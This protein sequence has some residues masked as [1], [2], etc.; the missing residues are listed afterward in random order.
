[1]NDY[2]IRTRIA[3]EGKPPL[4]PL[5]HV[6]E[7]R[8]GGVVM[9]DENVKVTCA[10]VDHP[11]VVPAFACR[12]DSADRSIVISGDTQRS[13]ALIRLAKDADVLVHEV[14]YIPA[15]DRLAARV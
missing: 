2:D 13:D 3:D 10:L 11:P 4:V 7:L 15:I 6:H 8:N 12:F 14:L 1:M 9:T 5:V